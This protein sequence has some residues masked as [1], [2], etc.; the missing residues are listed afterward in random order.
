M[1]KELLNKLSEAIE[2]CESR[3]SCYGCGISDDACPY[4]DV[5]LNR[6]VDDI[7]IINGAIKDFFEE[8]LKDE[9]N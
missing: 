2:I 6:N 1:E 5:C 9:S 7:R 8:V 3:Y 4:I